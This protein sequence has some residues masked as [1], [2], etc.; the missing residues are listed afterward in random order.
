MKKNETKQ[1][2]EKEKKE[3][4]VTSLRILECKKQGLRNS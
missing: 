2:H 3:K 1:N 4:N